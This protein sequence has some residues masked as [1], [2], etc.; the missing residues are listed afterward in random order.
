[1]KHITLWCLSRT[2]TTAYCNHF[3]HTGQVHTDVAQELFERVNPVW[4]VFDDEITDTRV[5]V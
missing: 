4:S 5:M 3:H 1:M 2:G